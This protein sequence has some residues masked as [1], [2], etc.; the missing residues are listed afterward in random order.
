VMTAIHAMEQNGAEIREVD[1]KGLE[2]T[3]RLAGEITL[4]EA[5]VYH[6]K[7]ISKRLE[8]YGPDLRT[9][10]KEGMGISALT[11]LKAQ[12][13]RRAYRREFETALKSVDMLAA[14]TLPVSAPRVD[15]NEVTLGRTKENVRIALLRLTR[16]GN[17]T[18]LPAISIPC[19]I[20]SEG[21]P[22]ALQLIGRR[23]GEAS[24]LRAAHAYEGLTR[25]HEMFPPDPE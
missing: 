10:F 11:Y 4:A 22:A 5:L 25:W 2:E 21:L 16:P 17:L 14:P 6:E 19:G 1:L 7:W 18:G 3:A 13:L 15:D 8:D 9:R 12:E 23:W 20:T 24:I